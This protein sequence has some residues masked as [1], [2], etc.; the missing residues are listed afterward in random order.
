MVDPVF[1]VETNY[2]FAQ[3]NDLKGVSPTKWQL[4]TSLGYRID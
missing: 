2:R 1:V 4:V 3:I